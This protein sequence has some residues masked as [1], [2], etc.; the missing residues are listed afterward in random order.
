[1]Q[2]KSKLV[3]WSIL[4]AAV[5]A[6]AP[7]A[8]Q[9]EGMVG[10]SVGSSRADGGDFDSDDS[11]WKAF[12]TVGLGEA[13][14]L[15]V[16]YLDFG[17]LEGTAGS[18]FSGVKARAEAFTGAVSAGVPLGWAMPYAKLGYAIQDVEGQSVSEEVEEDEV[19]FG[20]GMRF[21]PR[22]SPLALRLEYERFEFGRTDVD[23]AS[24]GLG[25][26]F[27]GR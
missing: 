1:M 8:S 3:F 2:T 25:F 13:I 16:Q 12:G 15:E 5:L 18:P 20:V 27:G 17:D 19:F 24:L 6:M 4:S 23:L 26:R 22:T 11:G 7:V 10:G 14:G 9:A 21:G